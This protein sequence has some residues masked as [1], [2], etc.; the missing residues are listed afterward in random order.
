MKRMNLEAT[1]NSL[2]IV[3][4]CSEMIGSAVQT[5]V[6]STMFVRALEQCTLQQMLWYHTVLYPAITD[7]SGLLALF[8]QFFCW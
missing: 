1:E 8:C 7:I 3:I 6:V 4:I 2:Q 5:I